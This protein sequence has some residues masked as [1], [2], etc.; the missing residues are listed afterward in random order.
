MRI[1]VFDIDGTLTESTS[2][3]DACFERAAREVLGL[4]SISLDWSTYP[5]STDDA[6][7]AHLIAAARGRPA[8]RAE[9]DAFAERFLGILDEEIA[10]RGVRPVPGAERVFALARGAGWTPAIATGCWRGSAL[11]KLRAAGLDGGDTGAAFA[12]DAW[13]REAII[14]RAVAR[15]AAM[16]GATVAPPGAVVY[17]GD[18]VW[19]VRACRRSGYRFVGIA[20]GQ[21]AAALRQEG[22]GTVLAH[23]S[24][25]GAFL[26]ALERAGV[27][28]AS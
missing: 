24:D 12:D 14:A 17:V 11:R 27:P 9:L 28:A 25:D 18:G 15:A 26:E 8:T 4:Q 3:D 7:A 21:R 6:I 20:Q 22:A 5:H 19:D 16:Q 2:V 13:P 23:Y 1:A 10:R